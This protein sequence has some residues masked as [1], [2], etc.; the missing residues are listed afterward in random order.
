MMLTAFELCLHV[1]RSVSML[2]NPATVKLRH[3]KPKHLVC[4]MLHGDASAESC[5]KL[6]NMVSGAR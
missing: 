6:Y 5:E 3:M 1:G 2:N 4:R